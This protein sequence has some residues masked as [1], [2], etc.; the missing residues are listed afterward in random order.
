MHEYWLKL[1]GTTATAAALAAAAAAPVPAVQAAGPGGGLTAV[2]A[3]AAGLHVLRGAGPA[4][5]PSVATTSWAAV[6]AEFQDWVNRP[7]QP[8]IQDLLAFWRVSF[9]HFPAHSLILMST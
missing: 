3:R 4:A 9:F 1:N 2:Y 7:M 5:G 8:E 6:E